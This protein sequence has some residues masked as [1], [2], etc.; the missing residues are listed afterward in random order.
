MLT[1]EDNTNKVLIDEI[2]E[3]ELPLVVSKKK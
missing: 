1:K 2:G 3:E